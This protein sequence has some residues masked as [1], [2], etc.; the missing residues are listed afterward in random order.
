MNPNIF[1]SIERIKQN[2]TIFLKSCIYLSSF[3]DDLNFCDDLNF[4][5]SKIS[6]I[7][8]FC[9]IFKLCAI[10]VSFLVLASTHR[11][12]LVTLMK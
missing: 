6:Q 7:I 11:H 9:L 3:L 8:P 1:W 5:V 10:I 2:N 12:K 4:Y